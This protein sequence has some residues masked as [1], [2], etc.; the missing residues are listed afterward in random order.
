MY[1]EARLDFQQGFTDEPLK[2]A[3]IGYAASTRYPDLN[4]KFRVLTAEALNRAK[5]FSRSLEL[6]QADPPANTANEVLLRR[7]LAQAFAS[8]SLQ[9]YAHAEKLLSQA[10]VLTRGEHDKKSELDYIRGR[11]ELSKNEW[12]DASKYF[13]SITEQNVVTDPFLKAY[14]LASLGWATKQELEYE[15]AIDWYSQCLAVASSLPAPPLQEQALGNMGSIYAELRDL[16]NAR[17]NSEEAEKLAS[18]WRVRADDQRWLVDLGLTE[19]SQGQTGAAEKSFESSLAIARDLGDRD[20]Q[21]KSL[22]NL[23]LIALDQGHIDLAEE[24]H[25]KASKLHLKGDDLEQWQ[26]NQAKLFVAQSKY[27]AAMPILQELLQ[28]LEDEDRQS[29]KTR[30]LPRW[31]DQVEIARVYAAQGNVVEANTWFQHSIDTI[32]EAA[33]KWKREEFRTAIRN[34]LPVFD[35]YV[36]FLIRQKEYDRALQIAQLDRAR[37]LMQDEDSPRHVEN[38][39]AWLAKIQQYLRRN[40]S[41]LLSY[42]AS[43]K[44]CY[45]WTVTGK[46]LRLSPLGISGPHLDALIDSYKREIQYHTPMSASSASSKLFQILVQPAIDLA[47]KGTHI[48]IVADSKIYSVNFETLISPRGGDHYWIEDVDIQNVSSINLLI[49][50]GRKRSSTKDL[51]LIGAPTQADPQF[52]D[53]PNAGQEMKSVSRHFSPSEVTSFSGKNATPD[54]YMNGSPD[55]YKY[56]HLATHG[57]ANG[58]EPLQSAIILSMNHEGGFKLLARDIT[59]PKLHL[60]AQLVTISACEGAGTNVQSL[61]GLLGLE[62]AFMKAGAHQVVAALWDVD[63]A[64]TP[65]LMDDFYAQIK[66]GK[67]ASEALRHSK[68]KILK[69]GGKHATPYYW[70]SLQLYTGS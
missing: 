47:P 68:L 12:K 55:M 51:L 33:H 19:W 54:S 27:A 26:L 50:P 10:A 61:E 67:S 24:Y 60:N 65:E 6:L 63:D 18:R 52:P 25:Q 2:L 21:A 28:Q 22:H 1:K 62:W 3:E 32:E 49:T 31:Q 56:I 11:C 41:V 16:P 30:Y 8:C 37:T 58:I 35:D 59:S 34:N 48:M 70:A 45:L 20:I 69:A 57:S 5:E 13:R 36:A 4:W 42:F 43:S 39:K 64:I 38:S 53:L 46:H 7:R 15:E 44:E 14:A 17:K 23:T 66:L 29:G 40:N 9:Q